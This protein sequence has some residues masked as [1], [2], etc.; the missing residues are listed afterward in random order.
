MLSLTNAFMWGILSKKA[1]LPDGHK[2]LKN[3]VIS[4]VSQLVEPNRASK[5]QVAILDAGDSTNGPLPSLFRPKVLNNN[6]ILIDTR[7]AN[8]PDPQ[9]KAIIARNIALSNISHSKFFFLN[10]LLGIQAQLSVFIASAI[11][12]NSV[13]APAIGLPL[14]IASSLVMGYLVSRAYYSALWQMIGPVF[15]LSSRQ[16]ELR[17]DLCALR[18]TQDPAPLI[19]VIVTHHSSLQP[20]EGKK[21]IN[22]PSRELPTLA[23]R[24]DNIRS[25]YKP[26]RS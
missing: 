4:L 15:Q 9:L 18:M 16:Q 5:L 22:P 17:T 6:L 12:F 11:K 19:D 1:D 20:T 2:I 25:C 8:L 23:Q 3:R 14:S 21:S 10:G 26:N 13:F 24:I 7:L